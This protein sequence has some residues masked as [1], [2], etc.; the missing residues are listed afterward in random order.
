[1]LS[2][3]PKTQR[4]TEV[5]RTANGHASTRTY[6][7]RSYSL[8]IV[9]SVLYRKLIHDTNPTESTD[10][11]LRYFHYNIRILLRVSVRNGP[12]S[13]NHTKAIQ[14]STKLVT[15]V[16][17]DVVQKNQK[18]M[19]CTQASSFVLCGIALVRLPK[20]WG[21]AGGNYVGMFSVIVCMV[22][23]IVFQEYCKPWTNRRKVHCRKLSVSRH[24]TETI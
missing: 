18:F 19:W 13:G 20:R 24:T 16:E 1:M 22:G 10:L 8:Y 9:Q 4:W 11:F 7:S 2:K 15:F 6:Q 14:C 17:A 12:S 23:N 21:D 5:E 3:S